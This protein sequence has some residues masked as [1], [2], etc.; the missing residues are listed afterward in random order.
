MRHSLFTLL[1]LCF[2]FGFSQDYRVPEYRGYM[3][4][5]EIIRGTRGDETFEFY[6]QKEDYSTDHFG[7]FT[8]SGWVQMG[9]SESKTALTGLFSPVGL[10]LF[11]PDT[12]EPTAVDTTAFEMEHW[13]WMD[14]Y[15]NE[16]RFT[17][18]WFFNSGPAYWTD[19]SDTVYLATQNDYYPIVRD[20][21][22]LEWRGGMIFNLIEWQP[23]LSN[24]Q[25]MGA[26]E[27]RV[28]LAYSF[29]SNLYS[30]GRCGAG[31][32]RGICLLQFDEQNRFVDSQII[33]TESC[34]LDVYETR[35]ETKEDGTVKYLIDDSRSESPQV[36]EINIEKA[37]LKVLDNTK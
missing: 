22:F 5:N 23:Q 7:V 4:E 34:Y 1:L 3:I 6:V 25:L 16:S 2:Q 15:Q 33:V 10:F 17:E 14:A 30:N 31:E 9:N 18:K 35:L 13:A 8:V 36:I 19:Q 27:G 28:L 29:P 21:E 11:S 32:E 20:M 26:A 12:L 24:F 37:T